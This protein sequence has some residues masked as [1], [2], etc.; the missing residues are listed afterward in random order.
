MLQWKAWK[1]QFAATEAVF[2][3]HG[4][5]PPLS[6]AVIRADGLWRAF[7]LTSKEKKE[8]LWVPVFSCPPHSPC[9][10]THLYHTMCH[11]FLMHSATRVHVWPPPLLQFGFIPLL[12]NQ[13]WRV[14]HQDGYGFW[15]SLWRDK[16]EVIYSDVAVSDSRPGIKLQLHRDDEVQ[17]VM[18][19][20]ERCTP[21]WSS[22]TAV[23]EHRRFESCVPKHSQSIFYFLLLSEKVSNQYEN[24][25][26]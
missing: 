10:H 24:L 15:Q 2:R 8:I 13:K 22:W 1:R 23:D 9:T 14:N 21:A 12:C 17:D 3:A 20:A 5:P 11:L 18:I 19:K 6:C 25:R 4:H 26:E 7:E 16:G